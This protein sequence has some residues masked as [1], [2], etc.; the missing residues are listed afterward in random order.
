MEKIGKRSLSLIRHILPAFNT[1]PYFW[2]FLMITIWMI[3]IA[4]KIKN[5]R[6]K[7]IIA[8]LVAIPL[9]LCV[10]EMLCLDL[11]MEYVANRNVIR[12]PQNF[13]VYD[14]YLGGVL[15][16]NNKAHFIEKYKKKTVYDAYYTINQYGLRETPSSNE[17]SDKC[18]LFFGD[19]FMF[20]YGLNDSETLPNLVG[21]QTYNKYKIYNFGV[22]G[23]GPNHMLSAIEHG[24]TD[25]IINNC[26]ESTAIYEGIPHQISRIAGTA[27]WETKDPKYSL[28]NGDVIYQGP[29]GEDKFKLPLVVRKFFAKFQVY[30]Y[31]NRLMIEKRESLTGK[32]KI[33]CE[34]LYATI[35][36]KSEQLLKEKY[37]TKQFVFLYWNWYDKESS[38]VFKDYFTEYYLSSDILHN[39]DKNREK[40]FMMHDDHPTKLANEILAKFL[41]N[42]L[43]SSH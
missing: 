10:G 38:D 16:K 42:K 17:K 27:F 33:K 12:E 18:L 35:L 28:I 34:K 3:V 39:F 31:V 2:V 7:L 9:V 21:R 37:N 40:Y 1:A 20:G 22:M 32:R 19:S 36:K 29:F 6:A 5:Q 14:S 25:N 30:V 15:L 13:W 43:K 23:Y 41:A 26:S 4:I 24:F 8:N 11:N